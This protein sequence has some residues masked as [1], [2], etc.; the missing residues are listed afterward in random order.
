M[1]SILQETIHAFLS[2]V[3][4]DYYEKIDQSDLS[5]FYEN[6]P[7]KKYHYRKMKDQ[8]PLRAYIL[9]FFEFNV[10]I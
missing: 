6:H 9:I 8:H 2:I 10:N 3:L 4:H 1:I 7:R 5:F